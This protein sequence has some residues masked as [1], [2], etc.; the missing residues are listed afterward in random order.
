MKTAP[1]VALPP[2]ESD[3]LLAL[4]QPPGRAKHHAQAHARH[5][6]PMQHA[7]WAAARLC[8]FRTSLNEGIP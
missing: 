7:G 5:L 3:E 6:L 1:L 2:A 8:I 4:V